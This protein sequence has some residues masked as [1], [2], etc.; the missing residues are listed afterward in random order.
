MQ[1]LG[2][3]PLVLM[4]A[5]YCLR[6]MMDAECAAAQIEAYV[7]REINFPVGILQAVAKGAGPMILPELYV[8]LKFAG[9]GLWMIDLSAPV[10]D[11]SVRL[12]YRGNRY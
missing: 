7:V 3:L 6:K 1:D 2:G 11:H 4:L 5:E 12:S 8:G 9:C 10:P